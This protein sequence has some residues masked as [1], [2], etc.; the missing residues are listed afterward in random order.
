MP[1][2]LNLLGVLSLIISFALSC[3]ASCVVLHHSP[4]LHSISLSDCKVFT[5]P[6]QA[7]KLFTH[8][9]RNECDQVLVTDFLRYVPIP[10]KT[11]LGIVYRQINEHACPQTSHISKLYKEIYD[12]QQNK[13][14]LMAK[15][16]AEISEH[17]HSNHSVSKMCHSLR[18]KF[19]MSATKARSNTG[20]RRYMCRAFEYQ[21]PDKQGSLPAS[22]ARRCLGRK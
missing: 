13:S 9:E 15:R 18:H 3:S 1:G 6:E 2:A 20:A 10:K 17:K 14:L 19:L 8:L 7:D 11:F 4:Q 21:D 5:T 12:E 22:Q 16:R